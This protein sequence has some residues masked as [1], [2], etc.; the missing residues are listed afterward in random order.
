MKTI[1]VKS[2]FVPTAAVATPDGI[3]W[4]EVKG[5]E[6]YTYDSYKKLP[7]TV[8]YDGILYLKV[9]FNSDTDT[10]YYK[11]TTIEKVAVEV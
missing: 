4:L 2:A 9:S 8:R 6:D 7:L 11:E 1:E 10:I 5:T 3:K